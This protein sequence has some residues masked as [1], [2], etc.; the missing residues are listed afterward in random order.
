MAALTFLEQTGHFAHFAGRSFVVLPQALR[1]PGELR[2]Q[3]HKILMGALPLALVA[4]LDIGVVIWMH[5]RGVLF[6]LNPGLVRFFPEALALAVVLEFA[7]LGAGFIVAGRAGASL[8]AEIGSMRL[9]E[10]I[11]ALEMLGV[12]PLRYLVAPRV[13]A[14][15]LALPLLAIFMAFLAIGGSFAAE[16]LGGGLF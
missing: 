14:C 8:G 1:R 12:S 7:P 13:L 6:R 16:V 15:V 9:T 10:Q 4:G 11:D 3:F 5:L 2:G